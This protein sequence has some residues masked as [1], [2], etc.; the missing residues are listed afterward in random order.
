MFVFY[1]AQFGCLLLLFLMLPA[2]G[3]S[4]CYQQRLSTYRLLTGGLWL[5]CTERLFV[6]SRACHQS[7][8][9]LADGP[10]ENVLKRFKRDCI[11]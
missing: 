1:V 9:A 10:Q 2:V 3:G 4:C 5:L 8:V 7:A 11:C 6:S